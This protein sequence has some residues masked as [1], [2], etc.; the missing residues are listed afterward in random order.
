MSERRGYTTSKEA[1]TRGLASI[2]EGAPGGGGD[3]RENYQHR[4]W[5]EKSSG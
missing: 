3:G 5:G 2:P 4:T 1:S